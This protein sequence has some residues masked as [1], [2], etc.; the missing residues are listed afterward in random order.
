MGE[1][2][3]TIIG[4]AIVAVGGAGIGAF[5]QWFISQKEQQRH[6]S[7]KSYQTEQ[8]M[9][10]NIRKTFIMS[11]PESSD[12][13][14]YINHFMSREQYH[15]PHYDTHDLDKCLVISME[16][17]KLEYKKKNYKI[18]HNK[19]TRTSQ[20]PSRQT[21]SQQEHSEAL[22]RIRDIKTILT[23]VITHLEGMSR[24][25]FKHSYEADLKSYIEQ[26]IPSEPVK[27]SREHICISTK[28]YILIYSEEKQQFFLYDNVEQKQDQEILLEYIPEK[29]RKNK[30]LQ[31]IKVSPGD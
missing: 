30:T 9:L 27:A 8:E 14:E 10:R 15:L 7:E 28:Y 13:P 24:Y 17:F 4:T 18:L 1:I 12:S 2:W 29:L 6:A 20:T 22:E 5:G 26:F 3:I 21:I 11:L 31:S 25:Q 16:I 23:R 19:T